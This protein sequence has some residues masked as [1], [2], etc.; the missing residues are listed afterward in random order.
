[1]LRFGSAPFLECSSKGDKRFSAFYARIKEYGNK[2]I[3][4]L[5]QA[6]KVFANGETG[7]H[8]RQAKGRKAINMK[9]C[10]EWYE[11]LWLKYIEENEDLIDV[12]YHSSGFQ[13]TFGQTGHVCQAEEIWKIKQLLK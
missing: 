6:K 4:E 12:I 3:E 11:Y 8:W 5:Y 13:D 10:A 9:E 7:L 1:M 2:S